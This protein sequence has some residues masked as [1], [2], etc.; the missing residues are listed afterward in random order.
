MNTFLDTVAASLHAE[1]KGNLSDVTIVFPNKRASLFFNRALA[2]FQTPVWS[3]RYVTISELFRSCSPD[4]ELA[5]HIDLII[6]LYKVYCN[7]TGS[8]ESLDQFYGWGEMMLADFDDIDKHM[9]DA[10]QI[11]SLLVNIHELDNIDYLSEHQKAELQRFFS[12]FTE[13]HNTELKQRFLKLWKHFG[14]IYTTFRKVLL[15]KGVAYE[16]MLYRR[17]IESLTSQE[18]TLTSHLSPLTSESRYVFIGFNYITPVEQKLFDYLRLENG[19]LFFQD[20]DPSEPLPVTYLSSPTNDLQARYIAQ[21]L[22]PERI[23]AGRKTAIVLADESLLETVLHCLPPSVEHVNITV[24][25]PLAKSPISSMVRQYCN[26]L[27]HKSFTL[28]NINAILRHP[29]MRLV[30]DKAMEL[31]DSLN[32]Q[33]LYYPTMEDLS[34]D[35][36]LK[37]FFSPAED[38]ISRLKWL[39]EVI[40]HSDEINDDF[41]HESVF[42][43]YCIMERLYDINQETP[44]SSPLFY[45][46]LSQIIKTTTIPFHGEPLQGIQ[47]MGVLETRNLDFDHVLL[48]SCNEGFMPAHVNDT[49]FIPYSVRKGYSLT[50]IDNK[51]AIYDYYFKHILKRCPDATLVYSGSTTDGKMNEMSRFMLQYLAEHADLVTH[52]ILT[53]ALQ[54]EEASSVQPLEKKQLSLPITLSPSS[55]GR[56]L[57]CPMSFYF[58][59]VQGI[60]D[61]E[62][63][64]EE[65]MDARTFGNIF[66]KAAEILYRSLI[67]R[68]IPK[69]F[70]EDLKN[71]RGNVSLQRIVD[72]AFR[73]E[74]FNLKDSN[75]KMP[76]LG[77]LQVINREMVLRFLKNLVSYDAKASSLTILGLEMPIKETI[78]PDVNIT[79]FIDR[80]DKVVIDGKE[81][82]RVIDYKTGRLSGRSNRLK[83]SG[84]EDIFLPESIKYHSN[85]FL[86]ALLYCNM[87]SDSAKEENKRMV[88]DLPLQ[89]NLFYVQH[90]NDESYTPNLILDNVAIRDARQYKEPFMQGVKKLIDEMLNKENTFPRTTDTTHCKTCSYRELCNINNNN[91]D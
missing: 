62:D 51:V 52:R 1:F 6:T 20:D 55:L 38:I 50:T 66:H 8:E 7:I 84:V 87:L 68:T 39:V 75:R 60:S 32:E 78:F 29:Y 23:A 19:A 80:L 36:N 18:I 90:M 69:S 88:S 28:H 40:A 72:E 49:S 57:R 65:E 73:L 67:G 35:E 33:S 71:E 41:F 31:H 21:W 12:N 25:Y 4:I 82:I 9:A 3:P 42:R 86:Q 76:K 54:A 83:L 22:T 63:S 14:D 47:I 13:N 91:I 59:K 5:D 46:L 64:D 85:Y 24:G 11:F 81:Y 30:S 53:P 27:Q 58:Y 56:Y 79:G 2:T 89:P 74:L 43:M 34:L 48:L 61:V 10:S 15:E 45:N 17:V 70:F 26:L 77:G 16:G 37:V 44:L